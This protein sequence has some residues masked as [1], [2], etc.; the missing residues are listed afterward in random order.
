ML[1]FCLQ[2]GLTECVFIL[3]RVDCTN[4]QCNYTQETT[5][6]ESCQ[7]CH[8]L[9]KCFNKVVRVLKVEGSLLRHITSN[10]T[11]KS[12]LE[13]PFPFFGIQYQVI[14]SFSCEGYF[15]L[16]TQSVLRSRVLV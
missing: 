11:L 16:Y 13:N 14:N 1:K 6:S 5:N 7:K 15:A 4:R 10:Q 9:E 8:D 2:G 3:Q 12:F